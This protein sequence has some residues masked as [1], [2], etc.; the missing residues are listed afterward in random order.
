MD[1]TS[2]TIN[3]PKVPSTVELRANPARPGSTTWAVNAEGQLYPFGNGSQGYERALLA[4]QRFEAGLDKPSAYI[5][6]RGLT[7]VLLPGL[8]KHGCGEVEDECQCRAIAAA[9]QAARGQAEA[10]ADYHN[11]INRWDEQRIGEGITVA[12]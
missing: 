7:Q 10:D 5:A 11:M 1:Y 2:T 9:E 12:A 3:Y 8:C 4:A 6:A